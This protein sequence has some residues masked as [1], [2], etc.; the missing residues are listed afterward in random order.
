MQPEE[1]SQCLNQMSHRVPPLAKKLPCKHSP[2]VDTQIL[3]FSTFVPIRIVENNVKIYKVECVYFC[4]II[5][6][7]LYMLH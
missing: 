3:Q 2:L 7:I 4:Q 6:Y 1:L 5:K